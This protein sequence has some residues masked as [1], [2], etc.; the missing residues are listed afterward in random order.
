MRHFEVIQ[1]DLGHQLSSL[2]MLRSLL[3]G[4]ISSFLRQGPG[5]GLPVLECRVVLSSSEALQME[6][7]RGDISLSPFPSYSPAHPPHS[8]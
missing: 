6:H 1:A 2:D 8:F 5:F 3:R 7:G 4:N